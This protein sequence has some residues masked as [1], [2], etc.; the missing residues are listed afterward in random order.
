[1][2]ATNSLLSMQAPYAPTRYVVQYLTWQVNDPLVHYLGSDIDYAISPN[3][4]TTP[5]PGVNHYDA[6]QNFS[7][8]TSLNLGRLNDRFT[9]WGGNTLL[10][11]QGRVFS[12]DTNAYNL[13]E[14]DPLVTLSD[15][16]DFP[17]NRF[18]NVGWLG[19][20]HRGTPWQTVYLKASDILA[21][22]NTA[23]WQNWTGDGV[24]FD[25]TNSAPVQDRDLFDLFTSTFS[26]N[27]S[28]GTLSV[29]Q[30]HLA[31]WSAVFSGLVALTN[32]TGVPSSSTAPSNSYVIIPPA[33]AMDATLP[34]TNQPAVWQLVNGF[35]GI[36]ATRANTNLFPIR[37]FT[38][39]GDILSVP[40]FTEKSPFINRAD[41]S[42][43]NDRL[44]YD[45]SDE[46]YEWLPQETLGLLRVDGT[47]RYVVYCYGQT[48][49]PAPNGLVLASGNYFGLC[50]NYQVT[51]ESAARAVMRIEKHITAN[52]GTN[53]SA[54]IESFNPLP[55]N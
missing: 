53:Y 26:P 51:A 34:D 19:R 42:N 4:S 45:I 40:A 28:R 10:A 25:A 47:P 52:G 1:M 50:T 2:A 24:V 23:V 12:F 14:R 37:A 30:T 7:G 15:K 6:G 16:W 33:G 55:P 44:D 31:A 54:V 38:R 8:L 3:T 27:A 35:E 20:V 49:R 48:L 39:V 9:P 5:A 17:T 46:V 21:G 11:F 41:A 29:N 43:P 32:V 13:A 22:N 18:P 36:N